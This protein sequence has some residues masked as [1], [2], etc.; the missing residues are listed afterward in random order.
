MRQR[1]DG[2]VSRLGLRWSA[3]SK[4]RSGTFAVVSRSLR[5]CQ[6][7]ESRS[8]TLT[9]SRRSNERLISNSRSLAQISEGEGGGDPPGGTGG[10]PPR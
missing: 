8:K 10:P 6:H 1:R 2:V 4:E 7:G 5:R 3:S 9:I